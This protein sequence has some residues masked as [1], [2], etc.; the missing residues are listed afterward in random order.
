M[1]DD[2]I[3]MTR[4]VSDT[5]LPTFDDFRAALE[6]TAMEMVQGALAL[7][8]AVEATVVNSASEAKVGQPTGPS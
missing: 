4:Q 6:V 2:A 7:R 1:C 8:L 5:E 3:G